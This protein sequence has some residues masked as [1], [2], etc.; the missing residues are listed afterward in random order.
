MPSFQEMCAGVV[1]EPTTRV[2]QCYV[3]HQTTDWNDIKGF[4]MC[5]RH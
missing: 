1:G 4:G 5:K 2:D 3:C